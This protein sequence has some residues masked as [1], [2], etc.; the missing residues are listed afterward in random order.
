MLLQYIMKIIVV[1]TGFASIPAISLLVKSGLK[2]TVID[3]GNKINNQKKYLLKKNI[4][5]K[6]KNYDDYLCLGGLSNVWTGVIDKYDEVDLLNWPINKNTFET[7]YNKLNDLLYKSEIYNFIS[8]KNNFLNYEIRKEQV[9]QEKFIQSDESLLLKNTSILTSEF[10][11][12]NKSDDLYFN[13]LKPLN[14]SEYIEKLINETKINYVKGKVINIGEKKNEVEII[15]LDPDNNKKTY[16]ADY[17]FLGCGSA[18]TLKLIQNSL[19]IFDKNLRL[20]NNKKIVFPVYF[21]QRE[22]IKNNIKNFNNIYPIFQLNF[23]SKNLGNVYSQIS[24]LNITLFKYFFPNLSNSNFFRNI[25]SFFNKFG[26]SYL[27]LDPKYGDEFTFDKNGE[28]IVFRKNYSKNYLLKNLN[29]LFKNNILNSEIKH[30]K[31]PFFRN[32][33]SGNH[34]GSVFPMKEIKKEKFESDIFGRT[35]EFKKISILDSSIFTTLSSKPPTLT[36]MAN[37]YRIVNSVLTKNFFN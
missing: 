24:N 11:N 9:S 15:T 1:G 27:S 13:L 21:N 33:L 22:K 10:K 3:V 35:A 8:K 30:I 36:I 37:S 29:D 26:F 2:P 4:F 34:F 5:I 28:I 17:L 25:S 23:R 16:K 7:Y 32:S 20:K 19:N 18:S 6:K 14:F 12:S 31:F